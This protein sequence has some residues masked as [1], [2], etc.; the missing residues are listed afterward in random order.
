MF[1]ENLDKKNIILID[2][3]D[4]ETILKKLCGIIYASGNVESEKLLEEK[5]FHRESL[6]ST[7]IGL[8]IGVPHVRC[9]EVK[10]I[11]LAMAVAKTP[12]SDYKSIDGSP[13]RIVIMI[14]VP[15]KKHR[16]HI[17]ILNDIVQILK[18]DKKRTSILA[19]KTPD[20][21]YNVLQEKGSN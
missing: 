3:A 19:A 6:M 10:N 8:G 9:K 1:V 21:I 12:I 2:T 16:Q 13:V 15:E 18:N 17:Q 11:A 7:G 14:I 4:K 20:E 5:I